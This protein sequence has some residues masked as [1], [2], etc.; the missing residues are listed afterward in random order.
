MSHPNAMPDSRE[1]DVA[2]DTPGRTG[3]GAIIRGVAL[4]G[5]L[6]AVSVML[7]TRSS[8]AFTAST[9]NTGS[10]FSGGSVEL[11][12][13]DTGSALF[14]VADMK[15][16]DTATNCII[17]TYQ[18]SVADPGGVKV[19][20]GGYTDSGTFGDHLDVTIEEGGGGTFNN[21]TGFSRENT[22]VPATALSAF[23]STVTDYASGAG[24]WDPGGTPQ[25]KTYRISVRLDP[26]TPSDQQNEG[27]SDLTF[28][29]E[30]QS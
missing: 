1:S 5:S 7:V 30:V 26:T 2:P 17:V 14:T 15:P 24:V 27:V 8:A 21:C 13:N 6:A 29:W 10:S 19:Y 25:S 11:V 23:D 3:V 22:I 12:D 28:T 16:G 18:G 20:S 4:L 9:D